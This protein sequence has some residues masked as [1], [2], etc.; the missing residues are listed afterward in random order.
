MAEE[1][2][3]LGVIIQWPPDYE[4]TL[5][6]K[7]AKPT[8][9]AA[10]AKPGLACFRDAGNDGEHVSV[11]QRGAGVI[12]EY[13]C[14]REALDK[15]RSETFPVGTKVYVNHQRYQGPGMIALR[16]IETGCDQLPVLLPN[17]NVWWYEMETVRIR[18]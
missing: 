10:G 11:W 13:R 12:N 17:G 14:A 18:Q 16:N 9:G 8:C 2:H 3:K 1:R 5:Q 4:D 15:Y 7:G 6:S